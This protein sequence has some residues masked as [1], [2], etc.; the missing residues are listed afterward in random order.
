MRPMSEIRHQDRCRDCFRLLE[1][2]QMGQKAPKKCST[3]GGKGRE[4]PFF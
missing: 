1:S 4:Y 3:C 2:M